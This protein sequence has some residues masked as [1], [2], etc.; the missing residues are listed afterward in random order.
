MKILFIV[1]RYGP[2]GGMERY[3]WE[4]TRELAKLGHQIQVLCERCVAEK[5]QG[6]TVHGL[7]TMI[8]RPRW[9]Y[10]WRF[11]QRVKKWLRANPQPGWLI[12][13]HER[14]GVNHVTTFHGMPFAL[15]REKPWWNKVSL[16]VAMQLNME[17]RELCEAQRIVPNS[18]FI[19]RRLAHYYPEYAHKLI[20]PVVPG[21]VPG[22]ARTP[23]SVPQDGGIIGFFGREWRRK[24]LPLAVEIAFQLR[25]ERPQLELWVIGPDESEVRHLF[26]N[27]QGG[28]RLLGWCSDSSHYHEIDVLLHP[29]K[30]EAYG[31]V[32][33]EAMSARVPVVVSDACGASA[34]VNA[35]AGE[36]VALDAPVQQWVTAVAR[37]M[38]RTEAP[39]EFVRGWD[40]VAAEYETI[41]MDVIRRMRRKIAVVVPKYGLVGGGERFASEIT[42][43]LAQNENYEIHVFA[44][45]WIVNSD[46]I[47]FHKVPA[48]NFPRFLRP[49]FFAWFVKRAIDRMN[50]DLVHTH[51]WIFNADIFS[52]HGTPHAVW[53]KEVRKKP[54]SLFDWASLAV[55]RQAIKKGGSSWFL[56]VSSIT[57]DAFRR[58]YAT[59]PGH[60]QIIHPGVDVAR[61]L[62][63]DRA[64]S[65]ADIRGRY[66]IGAS[67]ILLLFVGM[68]FEIKGLD[69]IIT[70]L[71]KA[72]TARPEVNIRLLVVGRG[73]ENKYRKMAKSCG[74]AEAVTFAGTQV[75]GLER[76]YRAADIFIMLSKFDTF[77][78]VVLE[79][80]AAGLPVI[81]SPNVGAKDLVIEGV[82]GFILPAPQDADI[83]AD[84]IAQLA[85]AARREAMG[86]AAAH[87]AS[88]H[89]WERLA[90][91]MSKIYE[92]QLHAKADLCAH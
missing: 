50:F 51:H 48:I 15:V 70:A 24:G 17:R 81:V 25:R 5:P 23:R 89:N 49:L 31:M 41:Y 77:G 38:N 29:A 54:P 10:Y 73:D 55:E 1:R 68:N 69:T 92:M 67:D 72:R 11:G 52:L 74:I 34:H 32:I 9:L 22:V 62:T 82:N 86:M 26:S 76:Y 7:G 30:A 66:G 8:Y 58:K 60:W 36:V 75:E 78:M 84:R 53:L 63:P 43:R 12:H 44:N 19:S 83:A 28:Y 46:R 79:A 27:W 42:M 33:T 13:S 37:Q 14:V 65:R 91:K 2:V 80:M 21:V 87:S 57:M 88:M 59:L 56:P 3:V 85:Y 39:P 71:A 61:F 64:A 45:R 47:K 35:E 20:Q 6:I 18:G 4:T 16:R 40:V 90:E